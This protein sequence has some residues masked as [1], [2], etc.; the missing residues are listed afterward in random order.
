MRRGQT[1]ASS[2]I[3]EVYED[4]IARQIDP[5]A[6]SAFEQRLD[7]FA[8]RRFG[9]LLPGLGKAF[10]KGASRDEVREPGLQTAFRN[11][12]MYGF[13][14]E[15]GLRIVDMFA[16]AGLHGEPEIGRAVNAARQSRFA[17]AAV[18][19]RDE[20][21][22]QMRVGDLLREESFTYLDKNTFV[23]AQAEDLLCGWVFPSGVLWRPIGLCTRV[24]KVAA[25][26]VRQAMGELAAAE[27][28]AFPELAERRSMKL[29]WLVYRAALLAPPRS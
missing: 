21:T 25:T 29:F 26:A 14:D 3:P 10:F 1:P 5:E 11:W 8:H 23:H 2:P 16:A 12:V 24:P 9:P 4:P 17:V 18:E 28:M 15:A 7:A 19:T 20:A 27:A 6:L 13:R 22:Q